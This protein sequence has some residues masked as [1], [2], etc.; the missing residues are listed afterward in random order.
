MDHED[1]RIDRRFARV[2]TGVGV[3]GAMLLGIVGLW[4][5]LDTS[6]VGATAGG[7]GLLVCASMMPRFI[8]Y[9]FT[10]DA[11]CQTY[12]GVRLRTVPA[13]TVRVLRI[14]SVR[15]AFL[16]LASVVVRTESDDAVA[17]PYVD[18]EAFVAAAR[19]SL[20]SIP[21]DDQRDG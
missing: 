17:F 16:S 21:I 20:P 13:S 8:R 15:F 2:C 4:P 10:H 9:R 7:C 18:A 3:V 19:G 6:S 12:A 1:V 14:V 11:L 5:P